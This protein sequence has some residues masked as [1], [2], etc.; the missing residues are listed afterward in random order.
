MTNLCHGWTRGDATGDDVVTDRVSA[1][2]RWHALVE[3]RK[4]QMDGAYACLGRDSSDFWARRA[5]RYLGYANVAV[6]ESPLVRRVRSLLPAGGAVLDVGAGTGRYTLPIARFAGAIIAVEPSED[7][8]GRLADDAAAAGIGNITILPTGWLESAA[9][10]DVADVVLCTHVLYPHAD[11]EAWIRS[12][13]ARARVAVVLELM[14]DWAEPPVLLA[15]WERLHGEARI[16]QPTYFDVYAVLH[17]MGI[18]ANVEV[19]DAGASSFWQFPTIDDAVDAAREHLI[20]STSPEM[21]SVLREGLTEC[22]VRNGD[23]WVLQS[24]RV[25]ATVW[26]ERTGPRIGSS[27]ISHED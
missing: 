27:S 24:H 18:P 21:D 3:G 14:A 10:T 16:P 17:E 1:V 5:P 23:G 22:L 25:A 4:R 9:T 7:M 13:D 12:L 6:G 11:I 8:S 15:L 19:Y 26:W 20:L 2:D